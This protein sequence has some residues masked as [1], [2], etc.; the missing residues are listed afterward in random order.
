MNWEMIG[1]GGA[2]I[3]LTV[4]VG[5]CTATPESCRLNY[6][7]T[8]AAVGA[9]VGGG[10]GAAAA[11]AS[12]ASGAGFAAATAGGAL[13][14]GLVGAM[15]GQQQDQACHQL[16]LKRALDQAAS[17]NEARGYRPGQ[18]RGG[19]GQAKASAPSGPAP[20]YE[21]VDWANEATS[22]S[23][24]IVPLSTAEG[25]S[26]QVCMTYYD[27]KSTEGAT[28]ATTGKACRGTDGQ[29]KPAA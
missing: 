17:A 18:A 27:Q 26:D 22:H 5:S 2:A 13:V 10:V 29:W 21:S 1:I 3:F 6:T 7:A 19:S 20:R 16:A 24:K 9:V 4:A 12:H 28:Q 14:G 25:P 23:G 15:A 11:A 8:G